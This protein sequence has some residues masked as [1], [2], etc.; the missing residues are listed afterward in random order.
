M[1]I[2]IHIKL[3]ANSHQTAQV[4]APL[5]D[6]RRELIEAVFRALDSGG[7]GYL[8]ARDMRPFAEQTGFSGSDQEWQQEFDLLRRDRGSSE[9]IRLDA[10]V[11]LVNDSSDDGCYC[12]EE[13]LRSLLQARAQTTPPTLSKAPAPAAKSAVPKRA[14]A[15]EH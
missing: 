3:A 5:Q 8:T 13:E 14:P 9:G 11:G 6:S 15:Q 1:Y 4:S 2:Y 10:F 12:S 7:K